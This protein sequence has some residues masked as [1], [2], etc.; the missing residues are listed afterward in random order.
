MEKGICLSQGTQS[1]PCLDCGINT[2][3][4]PN[5]YQVYDGV[6]IE[7]IDCLFP[8]GMSW[9]LCLRCLRIR[10]GRDLQLSDFM[11]DYEVNNHINQELLNKVNS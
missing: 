8:A 10:L 1:F 9:E 3:P 5:N 2:L 11:L 4:D 7:A 6:W